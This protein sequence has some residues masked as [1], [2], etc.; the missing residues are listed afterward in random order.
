MV[1]HTKIVIFDYI[2][3]VLKKTSQFIDNHAIIKFSK[4]IHFRFGETGSECQ[5]KYKFV[6]TSVLL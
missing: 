2:L 3:F 1:L 6:L 4:N 5:I